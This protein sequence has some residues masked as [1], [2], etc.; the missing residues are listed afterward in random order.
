[1]NTPASIPL[2][3]PRANSTAGDRVR[4]RCSRSRARLTW[5]TGSALLA[6]VGLALG[7]WFLSRF[8]PLGRARA[9]YDAHDYRMALGVARDYL[10]RWPG[11]R[12]ASLMAARCLTRLGQRRQAEEFYR[13]SGPMELHDSQDRAYGLVLM[14]QPDRAAEAYYEI[15]QR[16]PED[17]LALKRLAAILME[18]N[19]WNE[20]R[21]IS[22][23]LIRIPAGEVTGHTLAGIGFH[24][25][26]QAEQA[27]GSF[28]RVLQLDPE[29]K[30]MPLPQPLFWNHLALELIA[31]GR[32][33]EARGYLERALGKQDDAGLRELLGVTY[34]KEGSLDEAER[35]WRQALTLDPNNADTLLD[36]ARLALG[37]SRFDEA[38]GL[39]ERAAELSP[40]SV[41][42]VYI[43]SR[44]YRLKGDIVRAQHFETLAAQ[45]RRSQPPR[46]GMG[47]PL[48]DDNFAKAT[49][50]A[51]QE[52]A[53]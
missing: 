53:R 50:T 35:C 28:E 10:Q 32:T 33:A 38:V 11:D 23:R 47:E 34:E 21:L 9:A 1:M 25:S 27:V 16:W 43:L 24:V 18:Q 4:G 2:A 14:G 44:A 12:R 52:S 6:A 5:W 45:L 31:L 41:D 13:R 36:L 42:P 22:E 7:A 48:I 29:L 40:D 17:F 37:R 19:A 51:K 15:I 30:D 46:G 26:K 8:D 49:P 20:A 3:V 39:L